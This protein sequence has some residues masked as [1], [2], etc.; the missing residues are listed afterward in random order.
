MFVSYKF[1]NVPLRG[2]LDDSKIPYWTRH[3]KHSIVILTL[4]TI[5]ACPASRTETCTCNLIAVVASATTVKFTVDSV[6]PVIAHY[7]C[8]YTE[9]ITGQQCEGN[10]EIN[11][12]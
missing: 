1:C 10:Q 8:K 2:G 9:W 11:D 3:N 12:T 4:G 5:H 6:T 7:V